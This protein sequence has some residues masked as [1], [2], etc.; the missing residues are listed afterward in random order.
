MHFG[1]GHLG[2]HRTK[3]VDELG[4]H[5]LFHF[6]G[7]GGSRA[8][9]LRCH[10]DAGCIR[11]YSQV[12]VGF[13]IHSHTVFGDQRILGGFFYLNAKGVHIYR[14]HLVHHWQHQR[15]TILDDFFTA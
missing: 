12:K 13:H 9:G 14:D 10:G 15:A 6:F 4:F 5:E 3:Y 8:Q 1:H 11:C 7:T 2:R